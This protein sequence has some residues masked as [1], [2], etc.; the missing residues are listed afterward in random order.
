MLIYFLESYKTSPLIQYFSSPVN[1]RKNSI[2][3]TSKG[4]EDGQEVLVICD[5]ISLRELIGE[6]PAEHYGSAVDL[7]ANCNTQVLIE[8]FSLLVKQTLGSFINPKNKYEGEE[9]WDIFLTGIKYSQMEGFGKAGIIFFLLTKY[10]FL[11]RSIKC[12]LIDLIDSI[13]SKRIVVPDRF[14]EVIVNDR[15][16]YVAEYA[17][18]L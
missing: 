3:E 8:G 1:D 11:T 14:M 10:D 17:K 13:E 4:I 2:K 7:L 15:D 6:I 18:E 9:A 5:A 16:S 12:S